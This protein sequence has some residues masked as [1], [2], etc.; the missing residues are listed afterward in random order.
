MSCHGIDYSGHRYATDA[1]M[2]PLEIATMAI[3]LAIPLPPIYT[4]VKGSTVA[5]RG[6]I[7]SAQHVGRAGE[8]AVRAAFDIGP[9]TRI[10]VNGA[11][12]IPDGLTATV[13]SEVKNVRALSYSQ[14]LRDYASFARE[15]GRQFDLYV[16]PN[17]QLSAPL[18]HAWRSGEINIKVIPGL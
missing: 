13:L 5:V 4:A 7:A 1:E 6:T 3:D 12:R 14:Q 8:A 9:A 10:A 16:R 2:L 15:T 18:Q 17:T 11:T